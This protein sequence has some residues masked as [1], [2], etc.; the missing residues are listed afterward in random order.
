MKIAAIVVTSALAGVAG[1]FGFSTDTIVKTVAA[2]GLEAVQ[3][4]LVGFPMSVA[5]C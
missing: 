3:N 2:K 5:K 4:R 1:V